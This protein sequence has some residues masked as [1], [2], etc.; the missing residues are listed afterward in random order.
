VGSPGEEF[1][2]VPTL[3]KGRRRR[4]TRKREVTAAA[5][6]ASLAEVREGAGRR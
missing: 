4:R 5:A 2:W 1:E 6:R 3:A